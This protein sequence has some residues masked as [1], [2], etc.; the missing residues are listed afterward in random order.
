[1]QF[2]TP[3]LHFHQCQASVDGVVFVSI[4]DERKIDTWNYNYILLLLTIYL[5]ITAYLHEE[6]D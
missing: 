2:I 3:R 5:S 6:K 1:M 4:V